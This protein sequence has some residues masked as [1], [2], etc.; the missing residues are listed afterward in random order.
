MSIPAAA[1]RQGEWSLQSS[2][3]HLKGL[4][5]TPSVLLVAL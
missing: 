3:V 1:G 5:Y 4:V 2:P